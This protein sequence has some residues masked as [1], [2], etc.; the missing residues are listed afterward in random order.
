M[1]KMRWNEYPI[2]GE[3]REDSPYRNHLG[4][5]NTMVN[6]KKFIMSICVS[7]M[8]MCFCVVFSY[9]QEKPSD[10]VIKN[11][12]LAKNFPNISKYKNIRFESFIIKDSYFKKGNDKMD[13]YY[14]KVNYNISFTIISHKKS[15][16]LIN[17]N[18]VKK[19]EKL[20][21]LKNNGKWY[22]KRGWE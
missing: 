16:K 13:Y 17:D 21:L 12:I 19:G 5:V 6:G 20:I 18:I 1:E 2:Q 3:G 8:V 9:S 11:Y 15:G 10:D 14:V 4:G 22:G 7:M